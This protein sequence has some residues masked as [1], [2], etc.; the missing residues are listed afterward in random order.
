MEKDIVHDDDDNDNDGEC[1]REL[2]P[3]RNANDDNM[4]L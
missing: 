2:A 4:M 1:K 3:R